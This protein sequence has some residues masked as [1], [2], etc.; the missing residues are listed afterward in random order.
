M[1]RIWLGACAQHRDPQ[2]IL[3]EPHRESLSTQV[4][5]SIDK[6]KRMPGNAKCI[7]LKSCFHNAELI[8]SPGKI[9]SKVNADFFASDKPPLLS[10]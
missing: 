9:N 6:F 3:H 5:H 2:V 7:P 10:N 4:R 1:V 8:G